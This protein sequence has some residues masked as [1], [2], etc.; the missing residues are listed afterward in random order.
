MGRERNWRKFRLCGARSIIDEVCRDEQHVNLLARQTLEAARSSI[1]AAL[2]QWDTPFLTNGE[3]SWREIIMEISR[4]PR[5]LWD[6]VTALRG[7]D[8]E[9]HIFTPGPKALFTCPLRGRCAYALGREEFF[10]LS[11]EEIERGFAA[12]YECRHELRH[13]LQHIVAVW[14]AFY[15]P[16]AELLVDT[17]LRPECKDEPKEAA[18]QYVKLLRKWMCGKHVIM[19]EATD[20]E[21]R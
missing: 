15:P 9:R 5:T 16:L 2:L 20:E 7:P 21:P 4:E 6:Y 11:P 14:D 19:K 13:Y 3:K 1:R 18:K 12:V 10:S 17:F 8:L